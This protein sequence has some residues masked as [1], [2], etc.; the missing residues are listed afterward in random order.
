MSSSRNNTRNGDDR[1]LTARSVL[2]SALLG[3]EPPELPVARLVAIAGLFGLTANRTRVAL[4]RMAAA[5]EVDAVD[6][7]YRLRGHL[8]DRQVRQIQSRAA[9]RRSWDGSWT[10]IV[11]RGG[12]RPAAERTEARRRFVAARLA[13]LREGVWLRPANLDVA[14]PAALEATVV[15]FDGTPGA[16]PAALAASLWDLDGWA[17]GAVRLRQRLAALPVVGDD[18]LAPGFVLSASVLRHF[19]ADPLLPD[20]LLPPSWPGPALRREYDQW[21]AAYRAR[22]VHHTR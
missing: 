21:D 19:Q 14:L 13:E 12:A 6:G 3:T 16:D 1:P 11:V 8:L 7:R 9:E 15:R 18:L 2:A 17:A 22:L 10:T 20:E 4:S 5:G